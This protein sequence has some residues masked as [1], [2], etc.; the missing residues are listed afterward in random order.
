MPTVCVG[1]S[2]GFGLRGSNKTLHLW[3]E[4]SWTWGSGF[5]IVGGLKIKVGRA[6]EQ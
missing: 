4:V 6:R 3:V 5:R 2:E 1:I